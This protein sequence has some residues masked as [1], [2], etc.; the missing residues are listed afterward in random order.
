[1]KL[2]QLHKPARYTG[3]YVVDFGDH[4]G[5]GFTGREVAELLESERFRHCKLY[6]IQS[7]RPDGTMELRGIRHDLFQLESGVVF[8]ACDEG[9]ARSE[10]KALVHLAVKSA[11][12]SRAKVHLAR[13]SD[14][15]YATVLIYPAEM[16]EEFSRWLLD[17]GYTTS[18][19][20]EGGIEVI[21]G[22]YQQGAQVLDRHHL[23]AEDNR[24]SMTGTELLKAAGM[25]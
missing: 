8:H 22:Y 7:A 18:A 20:A 1:M 23:W 6:K 19:A 12:P 3:L 11:P 9:T 13:F 14:D 17:G 2:P 16:E 10:Y 24:N 5:V 15:R 25:T 4:C 21:S